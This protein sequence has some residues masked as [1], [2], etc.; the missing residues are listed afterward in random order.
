ME[1]GLSFSSNVVS[2]PKLIGSDEKRTVA[3][4]VMPLSFSNF[5]YLGWSGPFWPD[6]GFPKSAWSLP[7]FPIPPFAPTTLSV[8]STNSKST[9]I[10]YLPVKPVPT[11]SLDFYSYADTK[12]RDFD[13][14]AR[15]EASSIRICNPSPTALTVPKRLTVNKTFGET[16]RSSSGG[17]F[18]ASGG[19][20]PRRIPSCTNVPNDEQRNGDT[21]MSQRDECFKGEV[22]DSAKSTV[23]FD[24]G[25]LRCEEKPFLK[26]GVQAILAKSD[27]GEAPLTQLPLS[28]CFRAR[29]DCSHIGIEVLKIAG[30]SKQGM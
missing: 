8:S 6:M 21:R 3:Y 25:R 14:A 23:A 22:H 11:T 9:D 28:K 26:F 19:T 29:L 16:T 5:A 2:P 1:T 4:G 30:Y 20:S 24:H 13:G 27:T 10:P 18:G 17:S 15:S 7:T 12:R